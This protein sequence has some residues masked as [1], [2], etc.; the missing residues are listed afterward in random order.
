MAKP[1]IIIRSQLRVNKT[2]TITGVVIG[3]VTSMTA[4]LPAAAVPNGA[5]SQVA[6]AVTINAANGEFTKTFSALAYGDYAAAVLTATNTEGSTTATTAPMT[7]FVPGTAPVGTPRV[8]F[9]PFAAP[10]FTNAAIAVGA[11]IAPLI[12]ESTS[13]T[14]QTNVPFT[15]GHVFKSGDIAPG[16]FLV[17]KVDGEADV[18][19]QFNIKATHPNGSVRHAMISG[20]LPSL[21]AGAK[22]TINLVRASSGTSTTPQ[23]SSAIAAAGFD[24]AVALTMADGTQYSAAVGS[25]LTAGIAPSAAWIGGGIAT[26][27]SA[28]LSFKT[29]AGVEQPDLAVQFNV[30]HYPG[31]G[32]AK[33]DITVEHVKGYT[34]INDVSYTAEVRIAG[35]V[36][37][38]VSK[39]A[40]PLVHYPTARW[41]ETFWWNHASPVHVRHNAAYLIASRQIWNY[42]QSVVIPDAVLNDYL[43]LLGNGKF[44]PMG[45][46]VIGEKFGAQ[47]GRPE[48]GPLPSWY[49]AYLLSQ[50]VRAKKI[51]LAIADRAGSFHNTHRRDTSGGPGTGRPLDVIHFPDSTL[52]GTS[53]DSKNGATGQA[54]KF[55]ALVTTS[56][57]SVDA[58]HQPSFAYLPYLVTGD[59]FYLEE[60]HFW[61]NFNIYAN[62]P[63]YRDGANGLLY[64][65]QPRGQAWSMRTLAQCAAITP[66]AHPAK[67]AFQF[68]MHNNLAWYNKTFTDNPT[69]NKLGIMTQ[70]AIVYPK[71]HSGST[72]QRAI[73]NFQDD[74]FT[75]S[76]N[77]VAE[78]GFPEATRFLRWKTKWQ[79]LRIMGPGA[80]WIDST[81]YSPTVRDTAASPLYETYQE[82]MNATF[83]DAARALPCNTVERFLQIEKDE[84]RTSTAADWK[85]DEI[86]S[87]PTWGLG[88]AAQYQPALAAAVDVGYPGAGDAWLA[89]SSRSNKQ[90]WGSVAN[91]AI[92]PR[93]YTAPVD[94]VPTDPNPVPLP[95][96][97]DLYQGTVNT[98][99]FFGRN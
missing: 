32:K 15:V 47:G 68:W 36:V 54:E 21:A 18:P 40:G 31:A 80:C 45:A 58:S 56:P 61:M 83:T 8:W 19:L 52:L 92:I 93:G 42:D 91:F 51:M 17:G 6:S 22:K 29:A 24:A 11:T 74:F 98:T 82:V 99:L 73:G 25:A 37:M 87:Y 50:D 96:P 14:A 13:A 94:E 10:A 60:M 66:D 49:A 71:P 7:L 9:P 72:V 38:T 43:A 97:P 81:Y 64:P 12:L 90:D 76:I 20:V 46:G 69:A 65:D 84:N 23:A 57:Y 55:P 1:I 77:H 39:G 88:A 41:K 67:Q 48:I 2:I 86:G 59:L 4:A 5:I 30:R 34:A 16:D 70:Q 53:A 35:A 78:L 44:V 27:Y 63:G 28:Y 85:K 79:V 62:N 3:A 75:L 95:P 33:V 89:Y 26:E